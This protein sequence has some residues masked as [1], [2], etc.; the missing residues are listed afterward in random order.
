MDLHTFENILRFVWDILNFASAKQR[1]N[2][3]RNQELV[4]GLALLRKF[5]KSKLLMGENSFL[6]TGGEK[7]KVGGGYSKSNN[8]RRRRW[9]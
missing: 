3:V 5:D 6:N 7:N 8:R 2:D 1:W 4:K 9:K